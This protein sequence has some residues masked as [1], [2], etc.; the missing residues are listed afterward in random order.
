MTTEIL[1]SII[2]AIPTFIVSVSTLIAILI[3]SNRLNK[4]HDSLCELLTSS[5]TQGRSNEQGPKDQMDSAIATAAAN[6]AAAAKA[7]TEAALAAAAKAS[8]D[9]AFA[10]AANI[11]ASAIADKNG[12]GN[13]NGK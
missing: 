1:V 13:G 12:N 9:A 2:T 7:S 6:A 4:A 10:K 5:N 3:L 11:V 8:A